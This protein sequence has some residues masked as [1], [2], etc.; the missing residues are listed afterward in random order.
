MRRCAQRRRI[1]GIWRLRRSAQ[2]TFMRQSKRYRCLCIFIWSLK[3]FK[4]AGLTRRFSTGERAGDRGGAWGCAGAAQFRFS[5]WTGS[6]H[7]H[8]ARAPGRR[9]QQKCQLLLGLASVCMNCR[10]KTFLGGEQQRV[11][12]VRAFVKNWPI[13]PLDEPTPSPDNTNR[14]IAIRMIQAAKA[15]ATGIVGIFHD[16]HV[17]K[18]VADYG[19]HV[20]AVK[21]DA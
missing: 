9:R 6:R 15:R 5:E 18:T 11:K 17:R 3:Y 21:E 19:L 12:L 14:D 16:E 4:A 10:R 2:N 1:F 13:L 7:E 8:G 20:N